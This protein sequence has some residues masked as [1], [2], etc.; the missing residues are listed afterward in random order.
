MSANWEPDYERGVFTHKAV[1]DCTLWIGVVRA[2]EQSTA[3]V[4]DGFQLRGTSDIEL[5]RGK[6][7]AVA[8]YATSVGRPVQFS[9]L[10][11]YWDAESRPSGDS[12]ALLARITCPTRQ[13]QL[14][15]HE[16]AACLSTLTTF[17][18]NS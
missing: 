1:P 3:R 16:L 11:I 8:T 13:F 17:P 4:D 18:T 7:R 12:D 5:S 15:Q 10:A 14:V 9:T 6:P 2:N